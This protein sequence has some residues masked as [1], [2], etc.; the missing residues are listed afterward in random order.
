MLSMQLDTAVRAGA[1]AVRAAA[2]ACQEQAATP[3]G[4]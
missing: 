3:A 4:E 1:L 2:F